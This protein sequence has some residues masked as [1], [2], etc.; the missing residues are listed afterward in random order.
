MAIATA[1]AAWSAIEAGRAIPRRF[2]TAGSTSVR[3]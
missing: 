1:A 2:R 3:P